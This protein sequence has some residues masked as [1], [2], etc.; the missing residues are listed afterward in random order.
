MSSAY[1][2]NLLTAARATH[3][4]RLTLLLN[5]SSTSMA[6][7]VYY[8]WPVTALY[9]T[10][11]LIDV[12]PFL[13]FWFLKPNLELAVRLIGIAWA[14]LLFAVLLHIGMEIGLAL[15]FFI[16]LIV[17]AWPRMYMTTAVKEG[18]QKAATASR[19]KCFHCGAT[20]A[21]NLDTIVNGEVVCQNCGRS[22]RI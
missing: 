17:L 16:Q 18:G 20:Y 13:L 1:K 15:L 10:F 3:L 9:F 11:F 22:F 2:A 14:I 12:I 6:P 4:A 7:V 19:I 5:G 8:G 21:Y